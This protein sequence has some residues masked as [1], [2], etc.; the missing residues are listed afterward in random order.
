L[1]LFAGDPPSSFESRASSLTFA[2]GLRRRVD[3]GRGA[4]VDL[5]YLVATT[6]VEEQRAE[7]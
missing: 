1:V 3:Y 2:L 6:A 4:E 5:I 7:T